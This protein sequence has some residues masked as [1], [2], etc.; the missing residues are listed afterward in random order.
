MEHEEARELLR[1]ATNNAAA[2]FKEGQWEAIDSVA[3]QRQRVLLVQRTGWGKSM[4]Y[5]I[6][7]RIMRNSGAGPT[8]IISPLLALMRNQLDAAE[9][10]GL[11]A[12]TINTTNQD[13]WDEI[14][15]KVRDDEVDLLL[16]SPERLAN[17]NFLDNCLLP[18]ADRVQFLVVDEAHC[19]SDWGHDFRPDYQRIDRILAQLPPNVSVLAT[20]ATAN[21]RVVADVLQQLGDATQLQRGPLGRDSLSLQTVDLPDRAARYAWLAKV[22]KQLSGSGIVYALTKRDVSRL[23]QWLKAQGIDARAYHGGVGGVDEDGEPVPSREELEGMLLRNEVKVLVATNALGMGFDK[24]D[25]SFVVHFQAPQSIV[26]YYQQVGRAGRGIDDSFGILMSGAEDDE[27]NGYFIAQSF[28]PDWQV[29]KILSAL[30]DADDGLSLPDL[31]HSVNLRVSQIEKVLKLLS[32]ANSGL[33]AKQGSRWYRTA[34][35]FQS[36][37][38]RVER[39]T[40]QRQEE[41]DQ[42]QGYLKT[43]E[44]LMRFL[45]EALDDPNAADCGRCA[46]CLGGDVVGISI[47][48]DEIEEASRFMKRSDVNIAPRKRWESGAFPNYGWSGNISPELR[49]EDGRALS[50]WRDAGWGTRVDEEKDDGRFSDELVEACAKMIEERWCPDPAPTWLTCVPSRRSKDLV[51]DF[52]ER[53][54]ARLG[55]PFIDAVSKIKE[56]DRQRNM[57]NSWQ[58]SSNLDGA[59]EVDKGSVQKGSVLLVDDVVDSRWSLTVVGAL[60]REA[61]AGQIFP[62]TLASAS[63]AGD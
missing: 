49:N 5:F 10:L 31:T 30:E 44:C 54:A 4:V 52:A 18:I 47:S 11:R 21:D 2:E 36:D 14:M 42:V 24:P 27:I 16:V 59:F 45:G 33:V 55:L 43:D 34:N 53:L 25:L 20:T 46:N 19:I 41:W 9:R 28:P 3:N 37:R 60:L 15:A 62:L 22:L 51:P 50:I 39:L 8:L 1:E 29:E 7:T 63:A 57:M 13:D 40:G 35:P 17:Q 26:H 32:V 23:T 6:A 38:E 56:T 48:D 58:Q 12:E 61:G